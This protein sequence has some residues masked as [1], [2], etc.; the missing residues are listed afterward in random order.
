M[1][2]A[3]R[4]RLVV[5]EDDLIV[6]TLLVKR[7]RSSGYTVDAAQDGRE[8]LEVARR[9]QPALILTDW[10]MPEMDGPT[11][12]AAVRED[13]LLRRVYV[14]LLTSKDDR[15]DRV[16]GLDLG[17][18]DYLVKPWSDD[19]LLAHVRSG[20]RIQALQRDLAEAEHKSALLTMAA[21]LGHE[22]NN[23]LTAL[24]AAVQIARHQPPR[25]AALA[26][27][28]DRLERQM[29]RIAEVVRS[30]Q[31]LSHPQETDYLGSHR[32][33]DLRPDVLSLTR[34]AVGPL[35]QGGP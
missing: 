14:I 23:P 27:F 6:R 12:I 17:A 33:L 19:E 32:M 5:V 21:T 35:G 11:L 1:G 22:I 7:L 26:E 4:G 9:V 29:E 34:G 28:L 3:L 24:L 10:M 8:G 15:A 30:L 20:L 16:T 18:D 31:T 13:A 2:D 25:D